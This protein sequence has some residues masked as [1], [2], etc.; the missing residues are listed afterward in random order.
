MI[1]NIITHTV[2]SSFLFF[3]ITVH[4]FNLNSHYKPGHFLLQLLMKQPRTYSAY[5]LCGQARLRHKRPL[6]K[7]KGRKPAQWFSRLTAGACFTAQNNKDEDSQ[8]AMQR[9]R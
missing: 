2:L 5:S 4:S 7:R 3:L 8:A 9:H 1:V 6:L